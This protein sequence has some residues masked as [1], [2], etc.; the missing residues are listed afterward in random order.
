MLK[1]KPK[2][3]DHNFVAKHAK[4]GGAGVHAE[5]T[6]PQASRAR[7]KKEWKKEIRDYE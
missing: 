1:D 7:Q 5:K 2:V 6:G 4:R 3:H